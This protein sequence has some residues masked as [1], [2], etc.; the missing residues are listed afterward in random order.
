MLEIVHLLDN[1]LDIC[2]LAPCRPYLPQW[3]KLGLR[4]LNNW[5]RFTL[6]CAIVFVLGR[7]IGCGVHC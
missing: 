5:H 6:S 2:P 3:D 1:L 4:L 7:A